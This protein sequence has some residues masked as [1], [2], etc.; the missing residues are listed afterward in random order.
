M[1]NELAL[2][3]PDLAIQLSA[4]NEIGYD[5]GLSGMADLGDLPL[6]QDSESE[7]VQDAW[8]ASFRDVVIL[9]S[10][11]EPVGV[12]NLTTHSLAVPANYETLKTMLIESAE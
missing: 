12:F 11:N 8:S 10:V 9:N 5:S 7:G 2:E 6:F 4:I 1:Q 3:R